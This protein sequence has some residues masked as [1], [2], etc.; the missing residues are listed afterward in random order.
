[1]NKFSHRILGAITFAV[2]ASILF[3]AGT[4][5]VFAATRTASVSGNWS[6]SAT[7]GGAAV[8]TA[9]DTCIVNSGVTVTVNGVAVCSGLTV[10][11]AASGGS[12][13]VTISGTNSL[14]IGGAI[15]MNAPTGY[16][17]VSAIS[18]GAGTL[19]AASVSI[20]APGDGGHSTVLSVS[21]G[22]I[23]VSGN[24][25]FSGTY[26]YAQLTFT[27][28]GTLNIGGIQSGAKAAPGEMTSLTFMDL[29]ICLAVEGGTPRPAR[30]AIISARA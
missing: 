15:T 1:M 9:S 23:N 21:T 16:S 25:T 8:P 10:N 26:N 14:T 11:A 22:T 18:V 24:I 27:G 5:N 29:C 6:N 19:S 4:Y 17:V 2:V 28:A 13:G 20:A 30:W 3:F 12:N 7:W